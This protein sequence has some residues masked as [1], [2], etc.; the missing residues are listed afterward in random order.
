M[1][2][3][4]HAVVEDALG[5]RYRQVNAA[6]VE[7]PVFVRQPELFELREERRAP[8]RVFVNNVNFAHGS[9]LDRR[10]RLEKID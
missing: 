8:F 7:E 2:R 5:W 3:R 9:M 10:C 4:T 6:L 1:R